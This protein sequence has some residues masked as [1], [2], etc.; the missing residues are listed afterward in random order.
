MTSLLDH[1]RKV[2]AEFEHERN[3]RGK[4]TKRCDACGGRGNMG[5][6]REDDYGSTIPATA[7]RHCAGNGFVEI[8]CSQKSQAA[9][10]RAEINNHRTAIKALRKRLRK[11]EGGGR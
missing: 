8:T 5:D 3:L 4:T 11:L 10:V 1:C 2:A 6:Y 7:C 9:A